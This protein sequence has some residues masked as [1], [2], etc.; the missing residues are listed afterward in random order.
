M[1]E[2]TIMKIEDGVMWIIMNRVKVK[3]AQDGRKKSKRN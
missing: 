1:A 2:D 3:L